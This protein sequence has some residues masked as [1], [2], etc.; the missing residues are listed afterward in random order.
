MGL[1]F[2]FYQHTHDRSILE[3]II[4]PAIAR[5]PDYRRVLFIGCDW[6]TRGYEQIFI[7][8]EYW[9]LEID[10]SKRKYGASQHIVDSATNLAQHFEP[11]SLDFIVCNGVIGW[12]LDD[13]EEIE[14]ML[15]AC[16]TA[17]REKGVLLLGWNDVP[18]HAPVALS[19]LEALSMFQPYV[20]PE[21]EREEVLTDTELRHTYNF[22][23]K[24][25][26]KALKRAQ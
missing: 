21:L 8:R 1:G 16:W 9:T 12:G 15:D 7:E 14:R 3:F 11:D 17:L 4:L 13:R 18:E 22:Y 19:E 24:L 20:F 2:N 6:Y 10:P 23:M 25:A 26:V 5:S